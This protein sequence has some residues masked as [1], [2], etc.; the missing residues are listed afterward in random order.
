MRLPH[1]SDGVRQDRARARARAS[2]CRSRSSAWTRRWSIAGSTSA[3][4]SRR[5]RY[6]RACRTISIDILEPTESY[7]AGRFARDAAALDRARSARAAGCRCSSAARCSTCARCATA[8]RRCRARITPFARSS[9]A[10]RPSMAGHALHERLRARG[11][12]RRGSA[13]RRADRQR[14]QRAL[15][16]HALTG[17]PITELQREP[18]ATASGPA[19]SSIALVPESRAELGRAN[20]AALRRDGGGRF[21][22]G[23]RAAARARRSRLPTCRR[24]GPSAIGRSG[25]TSTARYDWRSRLA[26]KRSSRRANT[27][28]ASSRG[29]AAIPECEAWPALAAGLVERCC[30][31]SIQ[32]KPDREK[33]PP[34]VLALPLV[35]ARLS[36]FRRS[37]R[38]RDFQAAQRADA[39]GPR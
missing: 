30:R 24:C 39:T 17:R 21:R 3:R 28:S 13:S 27:P 26:R 20:R 15:E 10:K 33:R 2:E 22:C 25:P 16:V 4:R 9:I 34:A 18:A 6:A 14:I 12:R 7:S 32:R 29:C 31:A 35:G 19:F 5:L 36:P 11:S 23:G 8:S 38:S 37:D 1:G